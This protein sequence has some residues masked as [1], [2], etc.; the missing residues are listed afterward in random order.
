[1]EQNKPQTSQLP[2][3]DK[4]NIDNRVFKFQRHILNYIDNIPQIKK[5]LLFFSLDGKTGT[6]LMRSFSWKIYLNTLSSDKNTTLKTWLEETFNQRKNYK[7]K[8]KDILNISKFKGDPLGGLQASE[9]SIGG[10]NDYF[11]KSDIK[12]LIKIDVDRTFQDRD[13]FLEN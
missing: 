6:E 8:V 3:Y 4:N 9:D 1:M 12:H 5:S 2:S 11:D 10:W 13:L 7:K